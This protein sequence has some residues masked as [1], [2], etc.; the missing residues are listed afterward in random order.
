M[1][2]QR[3]G[4]QGLS[5]LRGEGQCHCTSTPTQTS[6]LWD[7]ESRVIIF[8]KHKSDRVI[9]LLKNFNSYLL[10]L[11]EKSKLFNGAKRLSKI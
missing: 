9:H 2:Q 7:R 1:A 10:T 5:F 11:I 4:E 6:V 8:L 3:Q